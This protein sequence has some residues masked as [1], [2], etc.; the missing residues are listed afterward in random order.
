VNFVWVAIGQ[1]GSQSA[2]CHAR[3]SAPVDKQNRYRAN[4]FRGY[5]AED[6]KQRMSKKKQRSRECNE[7]EEASKQTG[8]S[9]KK[10]TM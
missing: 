9:K 7:Q 8:D 4:R 6:S 10:R 5:E 2:Q 3:H 1:C